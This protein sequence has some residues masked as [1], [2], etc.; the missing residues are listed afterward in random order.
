MDI[1]GMMRQAQK[2]QKDLKKKQGEIEAKEFAGKNGLVTIL[3]S[4][5]KTVKKVD[6]DRSSGILEEDFD[7]L[8]EMIE[9]AVN[10]VIGKIDK[11]TKEKLGAMAS[12]MQGL[13]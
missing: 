13:L 4:G 12:G 10:D 5:A 11:E 7:V 3:M 9:L 8:E 2:V 6:I 1:Q